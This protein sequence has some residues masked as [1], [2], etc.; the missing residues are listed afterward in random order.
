MINNLH[1][2]HSFNIINKHSVADLAQSGRATE[3]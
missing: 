3:S 1:L 2:S